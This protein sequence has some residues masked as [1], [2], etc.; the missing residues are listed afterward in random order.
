MGEGIS[1]FKWLIMFT[2]SFNFDETTQAITNLKVIDLNIV[3]KNG[4]IDVA[5][6]S[7]KL[8]DDALM[9]LHAVA[10]DRISVQYWNVDKETTI[11]LIAK[12][13]KFTD[14]QDGNKLT[15]SGTVS[16]KGE[17][18]DVLTIYGTHFK[19]EEWKDGIF[20]LIPITESPKSET[21]E[22]EVED[23]TKGFNFEL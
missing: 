23:L 12:A 21:E 6:A 9:L 1:K 22:V 14:K 7:I 16:F 8:N 3:P 11:P 19:M 10:G 13:E 4:I 20:K 15:K 5:K 17:Q 2:I 18:H